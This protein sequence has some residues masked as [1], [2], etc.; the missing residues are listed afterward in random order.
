MIYRISKILA[1][2]TCLSPLVWL[3]YAAFN[4]LLGADPQEKM[5]HELGLWTLIYL[6]LG[7]SVTPV[8]QLLGFSVLIKYRR[9]LGVYATFYLSLHITIFFYFYLESNIALLW[10]EVIERPYVTVG[11]LAAL[12]LIPLVLTSTRS[13]QRKLGRNWKKLHKLVYLISLLSVIHFLWQSKSDLNEPLLYVIWLLFL[14]GYRF[15]KRN[16]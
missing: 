7:L 6:L 16:A 2:L 12:L 13:M 4:R 9:M 15:Y 11:M 14:L 1:H 8:R 10:E 3:I 5:L